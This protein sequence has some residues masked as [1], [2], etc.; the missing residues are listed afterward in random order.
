MREFCLDNVRGPVCT[1]QKVNIPPFSTISVHANSSVKG[2]CMWVHVLTELISG[3][4]LP[5]VVVPTV[6]YGE[7]H[8]GSSRVPICLCN[9]GAHS[10]EIPTKTGATGGPPNKDF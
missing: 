8:L 2:H 10:V 5:T 9:L 1:T 7:L 4:Q 3:P 6:T